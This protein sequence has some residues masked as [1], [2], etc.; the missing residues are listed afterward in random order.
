[1][2]LSK[3]FLP[4]LVVGF[5][6]GAKVPQVKIDD[7]NKRLQNGNDTVYVVNFWATWC[8]PCVAELPYFEKLD[9][10]YKD[11]PVKVILVST[12]FKKDIDS[13]LVPFIKRKKLHA[14]VNFLDELYDNEWIPKVDSLWQGNIP[15]TKIYSAKTR[16]S[17]FIPRETTYH[18]LDSLLL[19]M[20]GR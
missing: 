5:L 7:V 11:K 16:Q 10:V 6:V 17:V 4:V 9:S 20:R 2:K 19:K 13:R 3:L 14:E 12:D 1:M 15:A 8:A 18:E